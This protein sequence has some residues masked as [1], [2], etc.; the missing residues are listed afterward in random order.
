MISNQ[1]YLKTPSSRY[2]TKN[3]YKKR[4]RNS[5]VSQLERYT[6]LL[7]LHNL[8]KGEIE[9]LVGGGEGGLP[10]LNPPAG[11]T[12]TVVMAVLGWIL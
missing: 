5:L 12:A 7:P 10:K 3:K 1:G 11:E 2:K 9:Q 4:E 6:A 8:K